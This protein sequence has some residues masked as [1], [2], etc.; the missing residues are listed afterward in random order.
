MDVEL[1]LGLV[2][3]A[4]VVGTY[5]S[6]IGAG[7]GFA[8]VAGLVLFFDLTGAAAVAT[9]SITILFV[10]S[11]G[12]I[13]YHRK[14]LVDGPTVWWFVLGSV[15]VALLSAA[16]LASR[17][18]QR[19]FDALI[20]ALL[21]VLAAFVVF[22]SSPTGEGVDGAEPRHKE[23]AASGSL[24]GILSGAFGVGAGLVTVP[25]ISWLR[26]LRPHRATATTSAI[27]A[28]SGIA[29]SIGHIAAR[30]PRW[31][32]LPFV[33][34]GAIVGG[35]LGAQSAHRLSER[36]VQV[37]LAGGLVAAGLPLLLRAV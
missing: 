16:L 6:I 2:L 22:V 31:S 24:I 17:I 8:M 21:L 34:A 15:P 18:P 20:G 28:I 11:T 9:S 36:A 37:L 5:G 23:L 4:F 29:A 14:G 13:T 3:L 7:G 33:I 35:R 12:A 26:E 1:A 25:L 32:F 10:Q 19:L 27:G 30:N